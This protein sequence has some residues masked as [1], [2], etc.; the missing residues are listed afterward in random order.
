MALP[1]DHWLH[2]A[3]VGDLHKKLGV[4]VGEKIPTKVLLKAA[5]NEEKLEDNADL[6]E[7]SAQEKKEDYSGSKKAIKATMGY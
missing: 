4:K 7:S 1:K 6:Q 5:R 3:K 2:T